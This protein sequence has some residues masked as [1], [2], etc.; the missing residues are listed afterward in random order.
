MSAEEAVNYTPPFTRY[1]EVKYQ[2]HVGLKAIA[3]A[4][5][6]S[7]DTLRYRMD[8]LGLSIEEAIDY[9]NHSGTREV[10]TKGVKSPDVSNLWKRALGMG[11]WS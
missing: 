5:N 10:E 9:H 11:G 4:L 1:D 6:L 2:G 7:Y 8:R 3:K